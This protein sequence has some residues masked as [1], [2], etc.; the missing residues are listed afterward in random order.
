MK[1]TV[2]G[3]AVAAF[4]VLGIVS[5]PQAAAQEGIKVAFID[6]LSGPFAD[7][8]E[9]MLSHIRFAVD[10]INAKGGVLNGSKLELMTL[11][12][13][14]SA[15]ESLTALQ[16]AIDAGAKVVF[17][18][19]SG[20]SAVSAMVEAANKHNERNPDKAILIVNH[21][22]I[23][24][25]LTGKN[26]SFWHFTTEANTAMKM[27]ALTGFMKERQDIKKVYL[28][29]QDYAHGR[30]WAR[31]GKE[32][33]STAR[34]DV[35]FVGEDFHAI[36]KVKDFS[37]YV[38]KIKASGADTVITGNWGSDL[39]L[40]LKSAADS[41][42]N[43]RYINHSAGALPG[44]VFAVS[45]AKLGQLTWVGEWHQNIESPKVAPVA[46]AYKQRFNKPFLAPRMDMTPRIVAAAIN[47][48]N[49][50]SPLKIALALEGMT[51]ASI[52]GDVTMRK[53]DHQLLLPQ[54]VST[55]ASVDNKTVKFGVEGT[56]YGFRTETAVEGKDLAL[57][58]ECKMR[59]PAGA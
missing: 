54:I 5:A 19:G 21:S 29:N 23:D 22:S 28:L 9:L 10:D 46:A 34:S 47:K 49:S 45:Q 26:C 8:G 55:V 57:P 48:A 3:I 56:S 41:G 30:V 37:P 42:M 2:A 27:K 58:T 24:P 20:S 44:A 14:L 35:Q 51:Y 31:L 18:G 11:D 36:G 50:A 1:Q 53:E 43:L 33:L 4:G 52:V 59:R 6:P 13:K 25:D 40:L 39:N 16:A 12:N 15:Q 17:T 7:V 32:M 38:A